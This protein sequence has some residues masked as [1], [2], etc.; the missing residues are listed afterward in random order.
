MNFF[1]LLIS[2]LLAQIL[3]RQHFE[4]E[5]EVVRYGLRVAL[6]MCSEFQAIDKVRTHYRLNFSFSLVLTKVQTKTKNQEF[7]ANFDIE[8][9]I[10]SRQVDCVS[11]CLLFCNILRREGVAVCFSIVCFEKRYKVPNYFLFFL[12]GKMFDWKVDWRAKLFEK[13]CLV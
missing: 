1:R 9:S 4:T 2:L 5:D 6:W 13:L 11:A 12:L 10:Q 7:S 8:N 3:H